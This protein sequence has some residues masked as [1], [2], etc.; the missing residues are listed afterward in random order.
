MAELPSVSVAMATYN[1]G[2]FLAEQLES[3]TRQRV[4][5]YEL[6]VSDD[7]STDDTVAVVERFARE[8]PFPVHLEV[9]ERRL[10]FAD[11]FLRAAGRCA[12]EAIAFCDQDDVWLPDRIGRAAG[13]LTADGVV[14][15]LHATRVVS[16]D[17][18][19]TGAV[20]PAIDRDHVAPARTTD[21]W[22]L[23]WG[24]AMTFVRRLAEVPADR[25]PPSHEP[26][27]SALNHDEWIYLLARATGS[28]AFIA[29]PGGLYR[30]HGGNLEGAPPRGPR[31][32]V[33]E[34]R[35]VRGDYYA[36]RS[37]QASASADVLAELGATEGAAEYGALSRILARR[38]AL[39]DGSVPRHTRLRQVGGLA[40]GGAYRS[41]PGRLLKDLAAATS[42][43]RQR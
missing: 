13:A 3:M 33:R 21:P 5:P 26:G 9:N 34:V 16:E 22:L 15:A 31:A 7:G 32:F 10:G 6:V 1:G 38:A 20:F 43:A 14:L 42:G 27:R 30:Q 28:I 8:S 11:N 19:P 41:A 35:A 37:A 40:A 23:V 18:R 2:R 36:A 12:G 25:R 4:L 17:L 24:M 29:E 39:Y